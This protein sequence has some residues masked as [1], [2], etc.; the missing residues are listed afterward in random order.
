MRAP[1]LAPVVAMFAG[2]LA[3]KVAEFGAARALDGVA[4][5]RELNGPSAVGAKLEL[6]ATLFG[7]DHLLIDFL[8]GLTGLLANMVDNI[9]DTLEL[10]SAVQAAEALACGVRA[11]FYSDVLFTFTVDNETA[12]ELAAE[13]KDTFGW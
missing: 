13:T 5:L 9:R 4:S 8:L 7:V 6:A 11:S 3:A 10:G 2:R 12:D 1:D